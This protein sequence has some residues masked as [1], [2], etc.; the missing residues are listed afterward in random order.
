RRES[1]PVR[2]E[3]NP[4]YDLLRIKVCGVFVKLFHKQQELLHPRWRDFDFNFFAVDFCRA[5]GHVRWRERDLCHSY[6]NLTICCSSGTSCVSHGGVARRSA[7]DMF[8][9]DWTLRASTSPARR[10]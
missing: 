9:R 5:E 10:L 8:M 6:L 1:P 2:F 4:T 7:A 3:K